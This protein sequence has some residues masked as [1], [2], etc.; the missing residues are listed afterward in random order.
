MLEAIQ[1]ILGKVGVYALV[2]AFFGV[3]VFVHELGHFIVARLCG[4]VVEVFSIGFGPA[5]WKKKVRGVTYKIG[6]IPFGGYVAL[7]QL[8]PT[9]MAAIQGTAGEAGSEQLPR[10]SPWLKIL[11]SMAGAAGNVV[12]AVLIAWVVYWVGMPATTASQDTVIGYIDTNCVAYLNGVRIGDRIHSVNGARVP[13]WSDFIQEASLYDEVLLLLDTPDDDRKT[14]SVPTDEW[15]YGMRVIA[16]IEAQGPCVVEE[17][18]EDMSAM[19]AGVAAMD[20][21]TGFAGI[22]VMSPSHLI[23]LVEA[24]GDASVP[25]TVQRVEDGEEVEKT[26]TVRPTYDP[27]YDR[28]R[29]GIMFATTRFK[30]HPWPADQ[31]RHHSSAIFRFLKS[32]VTPKKAR[33]ASKL[34]GGPVAIVSYYVGIINASLMLA[35]WFTGFLNVNLAVINLLPLP[36]LDGGHIMFSLW[37]VITRRPPR[38]RVVNVL[39]NLFAILLIGVFVL[40]SLRDID[41]HTPLGQFVRRLL[42]REPPSQEQ[43]FEPDAEPEPVPQ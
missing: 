8:D 26:F 1:G 12:L 9:S 29:I 20:V 16:G 31:L 4:M 14:V 5:L 39:V 17:V 38:P 2:V 37:E 33:R 19:R 11:V 7:P 15:Q 23:S 21:I 13:K 25:I 30:V 40:L 10:V 3:T 32:L 43:M 18:A 41:R 6:V 35:L 28:T 34:V 24:H 36:V 42:K 27:T 22:D